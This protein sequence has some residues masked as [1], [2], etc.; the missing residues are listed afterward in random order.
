MPMLKIQMTDDTWMITTTLRV[1][2][3]GKSDGLREWRVGYHRNPNIK[4]LTT[5]EGLPIVHSVFEVLS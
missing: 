3:T 5:K 4:A 2:K 1:T